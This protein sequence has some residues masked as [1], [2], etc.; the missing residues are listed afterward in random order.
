MASI[1]PSLETTHPTSTTTTTIS[2]L[3]SELARA[4]S[5]REGINDDHPTPGIDPAVLQQLQAVS[6]HM[7]TMNERLSTAV[8]QIDNGMHGRMD[9]LDRRLDSIGSGLKILVSRSDGKITRESE[10]TA[11]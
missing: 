4:I 5:E 9:G 2:E 11:E 10:K 7:Q 1:N 8:W 3:L 6:A